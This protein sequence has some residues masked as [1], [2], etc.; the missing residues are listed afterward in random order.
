MPAMRAPEPRAAAEAFSAV[1]ELRQYTLKPGRRDEL[2]ELFDRHFVESQEQHGAR[3]IGQFRNRRHRD[4]FVWL[5]GF[6]GMEERQRALQAFYGGPVWAEF[7]NAANDTMIDSD[8][9]LLLKPA[10]PA[11]G[12]YLN[13]LKRPPAGRTAPDGGMIIAS[14]HYFDDAVETGTVRYFETHVVPALERTGATLLGYFVSEPAK[15]TFP[16]LPVR[17]GE[18]VLAWF[19]SVA[20]AQ[21]S[22]SYHES[23]TDDGSRLFASLAALQ[24]S[25]Q[26]ILELLPT[27]RS[28]LR[29]R[30]TSF[31]ANNNRR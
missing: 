15:N 11:S 12:L 1:V 13:G 2:I 17:G 3:V 19:A 20:G 18:N 27:Q 4:Q 23:V 14:I 29:H 21:A 28:L 10:G 16:A 25:R 9:V 30:S 5:R 7:R 8:N 24:A 6:P 26:E 22:A 31:S